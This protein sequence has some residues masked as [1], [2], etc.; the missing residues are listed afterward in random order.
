MLGAV[1]PSGHSI[2]A[3]SCDQAIDQFIVAIRGPETRARE[4]ED[5]RSVCPSRHSD[6]QPRWLS[7]ADSRLLDRVR[8]MLVVSADELLSSSA[9]DILNGSGYTVP[10]THAVVYEQDTRRHSA[11]WAHGSRREAAY[12]SHL[13]SS[14][15][16]T[17][18][19]RPPACMPLQLVQHRTQLVANCELYLQAA[20]PCATFTVSRPGSGRSRRTATGKK[21]AWRLA[22]GTA[23]PPPGNCPLP[24]L[25][26]DCTTPTPEQRVA[27]SRKAGIVIRSSGSVSSM[28][29]NTAA[30]PS[31]GP[32]AFSYPTTPPPRRKC[33]KL[34][35]LHNIHAQH[36][37]WPPSSPHSCVLSSRQHQNHAI[38]ALK[39]DFQ[40]RIADDADEPLDIAEEDRNRVA[41][42]LRYRRDP[43]SQI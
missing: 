31:R 34:V 21:L 7:Q 2:R 27:P 40:F 15:A 41:S 23:T 13:A 29:N 8:L 3:R 25:D 18:R 20:H 39:A 24:L 35:V 33:E 30:A 22:D 42:E 14:S 10:Q 28:A 17:P 43:P 5:S 26:R 32:S 11:A 36:H 19:E 6:R 12:C 9:T 4:H 38:V 16:P 37:F 1:S